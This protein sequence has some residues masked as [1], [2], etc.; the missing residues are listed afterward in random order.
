MD[1]GNEDDYKGIPEEEALYSWIEIKS[2]TS[3]TYRSSG[4]MPGKMR[5]IFSPN[6]HIDFMNFA[7][8]GKTIEPSKRWTF[9]DN[10]SSL[11]SSKLFNIIEGNPVV[12]N[13][14]IKDGGYSI[15]CN[16]IADEPDTNYY[17]RRGKKRGTGS[18]GDTLEYHNF[19]QVMA[20][21]KEDG[22]MIKVAESF[23][24]GNNKH[25]LS[26]LVAGENYYLMVSSDMFPI[27]SIESSF[28]NE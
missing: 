19:Q 26:G 18:D 9:L 23:D 20:F 4:I 17:Y 15:L 21:I 5:F 22:V 6:P 27:V 16:I 28:P 8:S 2:D 12:H 24:A 14:E 13:F 3:N 1:L 7:N 25:I 11:S 10:S